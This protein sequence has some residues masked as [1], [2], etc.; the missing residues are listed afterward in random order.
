MS[1]P[2]DAAVATEVERYAALQFTRREVATICGLTLYGLEPYETNYQRG[3]LKG[4][5]E[6]RDTI[7]RMAK[8]GSTPAQE[9]VRR[10]AKRSQ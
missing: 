9:Q 8:Q 6:V 1:T 2:P 7:V 4:D 10:L 5:A 3:R